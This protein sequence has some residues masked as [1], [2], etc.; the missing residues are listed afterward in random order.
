MILVFGSINV[1]VFYDL[2]DFV[3]VDE[4]AVIPDAQVWSGGKGANQAVAAA[5]DGAKVRF[6]GA[7]GS[8]AFAAVALRG[9]VQA[10]VDTSR[11]ARI[12]AQTGLTSIQRN[13][14]QQTKI[15][16][17]LGANLGARHEQ[18]ENASLGPGTLLLLQMDM[19]PEEVAT[20]VRRA[21]VRGAFVMLNVSP[22]MM[23]DTDV[24]RL[25]DVLLLDEGDSGAL[26]EHLGT[27]VGAASLHAA[28]GCDVVRTM[29]VMGVECAT[30]AGHFRIDSH[31]V[32]EVDRTGA[33]DCLAGVMAACLDRGGSLRDALYRANIAAAL[34]CRKVGL[35]TSFPS[36]SEINREIEASLESRLVQLR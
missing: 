22:F 7:V 26:A 34:S 2:P 6:A 1:D 35:Q 20:L 24:L 25:V 29:G 5:R 13:P 3:D 10:N 14:R 8:D 31:T 21:R 30:A 27:G 19:D 32:D 18:I 36:W 23:I 4:T 16:T 33:Q 12:A 9:L 11:V 17:A 28:L 15:V